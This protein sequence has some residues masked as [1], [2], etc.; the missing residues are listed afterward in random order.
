MPTGYTNAV[1]NGTCTD[2]K[3][4]AWTCA[5]A[6][7]ALIMMRDM[8]MN[9]PIPE[10]FEPETKYHDKAIEETEARIKLLTEADYETLNAMFTKARDLDEANYQA[11]LTKRRDLGKRY[12]D[13][14]KQ[15]GTIP[16]PEE[17][18]GLRNFMLEQLKI[19]KE[20]DCREY[21]HDRFPETQ[22][23][24]KSGELS[25]AQ[26]SLQYHK[27]ARLEEI[28]RVDARNAWLKL[29]RETLQ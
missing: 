1:Y 11:D 7:G 14:L 9:A 2:V 24:W 8:P 29:L 3:D 4:F 13:M 22:H 27:K 26:E 20:S 28:S 25:K 16:W 19:S 15:V 23:L 18:W 12:D 5:R 17:L 6:M 10:A 21:T